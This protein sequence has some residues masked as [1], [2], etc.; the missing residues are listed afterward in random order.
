MFA[1]TFTSFSE[2]IIV[3]AKKIKKVND[4]AENIS[5]S[6]LVASD[7]S[8]NISIDT[9]LIGFS[10]VT[11]LGIRGLGKGSVATFLDEVE[12]IDSS[13]I[14]DSSQLQYINLNLLRSYTLR[15]NDLE[16]NSFSNSLKFNTKKKNQLDIM[17]GSQNTSLLSLNLKSSEFLN[18]QFHL[19]RFH[20]DGISKVKSQTNLK[21]EDDFFVSHNFFTRVEKKVSSFTAYLGLY[22]IDGKQDID[23]FDST[24]FDPIDLEKNDLSSYRH[25]IFL[26]GNKF[27]KSKLHSYNLYFNMNTL[28]RVENDPLQYK[29]SSN[30]KRITLKQN[31]IFSPL[32]NLE[33][34]AN[35]EKEEADILSDSHIRSKWFIALSNKM[36]FDQIT[37]NPYLK[38]F[39]EQSSS[40][41]FGINVNTKWN[42]KLD[43]SLEAAQ[44]EKQPSLFQRFDPFSGNIKLEP[45]KLRKISLKNSYKSKAF[46]ISK[47]FFYYKVSNKISY[48]NNKYLNILKSTH[49]GVELNSQL[50]YQKFLF[51]MAYRYLS[52]TD[53]DKFQ[54]ATIPKHKSSFSIKKNFFN[55]DSLLKATYKSKTTSFSQNTVKDYILFDL[56]F[57]HQFNKN[58][59]LSLDFHN[60]LNHDYQDIEHYNTRGFST[61][62]SI[63]FTP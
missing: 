2:E 60:L 61:Y 5:S 23:G 44:T 33:L 10:G 9:D 22:L 55:I 7:L 36:V 18:T 14:N 16:S 57:S 39:H 21:A 31:H 26:V 3:T 59:L 15:T 1:I 49:L 29:Y 63:R 12:L 62:A 46:S 13:D 24:S 30:S 42:K 48:L 40:Y 50:N 45:E 56:N 8:E 20:S 27:Q 52:A 19:S 35:Y 51:N 11:Q 4:Q 53:S 28:H 17:Y 43:T 38:A 34:L 47:E 32:I 54:L 58:I 37:L 41:P 25:Y 6:M